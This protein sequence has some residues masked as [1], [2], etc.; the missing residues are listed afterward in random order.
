MRQVAFV[1][2][3]LGASALQYG[4]F[5]PYPG[6]TGTLN[7]RGTVNVQTRSLNDGVYNFNLTGADPACTAAMPNACGVH[8]HVGTDCTNATAIGGHLYNEEIFAKDPWTRARYTSGSPNTNNSIV[9]GL[10]ADQLLGH[11]LVVHDAAGARIACAPFKQA[12]TTDFV[13]YPGYA[14]PLTVGGSVEVATNYQGN[15]FQVLVTTHGVVG[16][17]KCTAAIPN[18]CGVHVHVGQG[19]ETAP[20]GHFFNSAVVGQDPW[21]EAKYVGANATGSFD[22]LDGYTVAESAK[23]TFVVHD[24]AGARISCGVPIA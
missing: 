20:G 21:T 18:A 23:Q 1:A 6:Y 22:L 14:G 3:A 2:L 9:T 24:A 7:V 4:S 11:V 5:V 15:P 8:I 17:P 12:V 13:P 16:D 19:C 10:P